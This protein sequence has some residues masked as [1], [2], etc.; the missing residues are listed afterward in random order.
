MFGDLLF[1][2][3]MKSEIELSGKGPERNSVNFRIKKAQVEIYIPHKSKIVKT[4]KIF[5]NDVLLV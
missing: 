4:S 1:Q 5:S 3:G 2:I